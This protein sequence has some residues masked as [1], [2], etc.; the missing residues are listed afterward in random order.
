MI[1]D[2]LTRSSLSSFVQTRSLRPS[3]PGVPSVSD[4]SGVES[5]AK[6]P[7]SSSSG[8]SLDCPKLSPR[9]LVVGVPVT[10]HRRSTLSVFK[11]VDSALSIDEEMCPSSMISRFHRTEVRV[12]EILA[13][14]VQFA[15]RIR[16]KSGHSHVPATCLVPPRRNSFVN[17]TRYEKEFR[18]VL[19]NLT[20]V[21]VSSIRSIQN[22]SLPVCEL[23][24]TSL[25]YSPRPTVLARGF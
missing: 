14:H 11:N 18:N 23:G 8:C 7:N 6:E 12:S 22:L 15:T 1:A 3:G 24:K 13:S 5:S 16:L 2:S 9:R 19:G 17:P 20:H 4:V 21:L 10:I 25:Q